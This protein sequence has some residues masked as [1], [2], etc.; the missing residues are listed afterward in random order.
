M[1]DSHDSLSLNSS[2]VSFQLEQ[3]RSDHK[4]LIESK[5]A[6]LVKQDEDTKLIKSLQSKL[7][8]ETRQK[9]ELQSVNQNLQEE[10]RKLKS[11]LKNLGELQ[12]WRAT[13]EQQTRKL[14]NNH[15]TQI[16]CVV[17]ANGKK[18]KTRCAALHEWLQRKK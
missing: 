2:R 17:E 15:I 1:T 9:N 4:S 11:Q 13:T 8:T 18:K 10:K 7:G 6:L 5:K 12:P 3:L 16:R 14:S